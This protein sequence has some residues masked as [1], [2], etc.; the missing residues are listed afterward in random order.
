MVSKYLR[1]GKS[2]LFLVLALTLLLS[3][4]ALVP[5]MASP[6]AGSIEGTITYYGP[7][8]GDHNISGFNI[9]IFKSVINGGLDCFSV[10]LGLVVGTDQYGF[11]G[12]SR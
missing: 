12:K 6:D 2:R 1:I 9:I 7:I 10:V 11:A 8:S 5:G 3:A 4:V